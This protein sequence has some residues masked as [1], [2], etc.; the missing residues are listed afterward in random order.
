MTSKTISILGCGYLG[1]PVA[2]ALIAQG[3]RVRGST[4]TKSKLRVLLEAGVEP[5]LVRL[6]PHIEGPALRDFFRSEYLF[7]NFP[8]GRRRPDVEEFLGT[9]IESILVCLDGVRSVVFASSTSVYTRGEVSEDDVTETPPMASGRALLRA[10]ARLR[11]QEAFQTT[12]LRF[13]GLYGYTRRPGRFLKAIPNGAAR[14][15][16]IHRDDAVAVVVRVLGN[17][18]EDAVFNVVADQHPRKDDFYRQAA[19]WLGKAPPTVAY[20]S[21]LPGKCVSNARLVEQLGYRFIHPDPM[22]RAP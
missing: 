12:V 22:V 17:P 9:A 15:N 20:D 10:E 3:W 14:V 21:T 5:F 13:G 6:S 7:L 11:A 2:K 19:A 8:P 16:L 18:V 1:L 4:T